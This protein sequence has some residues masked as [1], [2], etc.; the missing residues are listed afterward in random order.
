MSDAI[1]WRSWDITSDFI[2]FMLSR[3]GNGVICTCLIIWMCP[4]D[5]YDVIYGLY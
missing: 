5:V 3:Q 1:G 2:V 4:L